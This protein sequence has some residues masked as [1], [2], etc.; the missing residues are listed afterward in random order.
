MSAI[1]TSA[2]RPAPPQG[3][4]PRTVYLVGGLIFVALVVVA[5]VAAVAWPLLQGQRAQTAY[6]VTGPVAGRDAATLDLLSGVTSVSVE[7]ADLGGTLYRVES[8]QSPTVTDRDGRVQVQV[9]GGDGVVAIQL[10]RGV[11]WT[12]RFTGGA[13]SNTADLREVGKLA[14]VEYVGGVSAIE[15]TLP[16]ASGTVPVKV[17]GG[18]GTLRVH[19]PEAA[20]V[21]VNASGGA[22]GVTIDGVAH[23]GV[24]AGSVYPSKG[25]DTA[26]DR[27]DI[28]ATNGISSVV[29][30]RTAP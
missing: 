23:N 3:P 6:S 15:L 30:D 16:G 5:A 1:D 21:R 2:A 9:T 27:Y 8:P 25:W 24:G 17:D 22:G 28:D 13:Q 18:V 19:A 4:P 11:R 7:G 10:N 26:K 20:P 14:G 29:V 12:V